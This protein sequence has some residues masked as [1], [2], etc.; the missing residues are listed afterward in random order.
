MN[1]YFDRTIKVYQGES[2]KV[3]VEGKTVSFGYAF[4][5]PDGKTVVS[6]GVMPLNVAAELALLLGDALAVP[7]DVVRET[8]LVPS[9]DDVVVVPDLNPTSR[10]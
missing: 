8:G 2:A 4:K 3:E 10:D 9:E 7:G 1:K 5:T 6:N